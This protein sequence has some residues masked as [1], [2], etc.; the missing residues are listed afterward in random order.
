ML[1]WQ[2]SKFFAAFKNGQYN[3][4]GLAHCSYSCTSNYALAVGLLS[5]FMKIAVQTMTLFYV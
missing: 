4:V 1:K 3:W 2:V 5:I